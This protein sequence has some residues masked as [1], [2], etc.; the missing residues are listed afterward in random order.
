MQGGR[1]DIVCRLAAL[2]LGLGFLHCG[3]RFA[4]R[5]SGAA[6]RQLLLASILYL[7]SLLLL[8]ILQGR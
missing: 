7:P 4:L 5:K 6:A 8:M 1:P 2:L 3:A